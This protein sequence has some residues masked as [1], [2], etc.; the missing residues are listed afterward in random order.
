MKHK[1]IAD[2]YIFAVLDN[3]IRQLEHYYGDIVNEHEELGFDTGS[4]DMPLGK[5]DRRRL[6]TQITKKIDQLRNRVEAA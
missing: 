2:H 6:L 4:V 3:H 5:T 1:K